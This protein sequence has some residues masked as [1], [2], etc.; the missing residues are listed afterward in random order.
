M[1]TRFKCPSMLQCFLLVFALFASLGSDRASAASATLTNDVFWKD[2]SNNPI[3]SQGGNIL[4]VG[5]TYYWYGVKYNGAVTYYNN[6]TAKNS[7]TGFLAVTCY[8]STNLV[9]WTFCGNVINGATDGSTWD[10]DWLGRL[11]VVYNSNT[12]KYVLL[13]QYVGPQGTGTAFATSSSPTG[14]FTFNR[15]QTSYPGVVNNLPGDQSTFVDDNGK[16]YLVYSNANG[17]NRIYV[18]EIRASDYLNVEPGANVFTSTSGGREGN[19]MFKHNG[20]YYIC[21]SDL[22]GWNASKTYCITSSNIM[23]PYSAESVMVNSD[24]DFSHVTQTGFFIKVQGTSGTTILF[25][26]DRW[27]DFAGNG[28]G[29]NQWMPITFNGTTPILQSLSKFNLDAAAGTWSVANGN[30]YVLNPSYEADRVTQNTLTGWSNWK[31][32]STETNTNISPGRTGRWSMS[33]Y[34]A[35]AYSASMYQNI[36]GLPNG[37]YT[38]KAWVRGGGGQSVAQIYVKNFGG[39]E[40]NA[41]IN[42]SIN[43]WTE[44]TISDINVTN[45]SAQIGVYAVANAGNWLRVD[46][47]SLTKN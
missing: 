42:S 27:S 33:M 41:A 47:W 7:D 20:I 11:G 23:G 34:N 25:A 5:N 1:T 24:K 10:V 28:L 13:T 19:A 39:A 26:G 44:I 8:S 35:A 21:S 30:N 31:N 29:Y 36:S 12:Q 40:K 46:D 15:V 32:I 43:N 37:T 18:S 16:A 14:P 22:H 2:T 45:G 17:R 4:K 9:D 3:Y 6:P 38:L